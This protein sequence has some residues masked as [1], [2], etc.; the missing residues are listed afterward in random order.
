MTQAP[1][2]NIPGEVESLREFGRQNATK[3]AI[4]VAVMALI[5]A[6][7]AFYRAHRQSERREASNLLNSWRDLSQLEEIVDRYSSSPTAPLALLQLAKA[8]F[9]NGNY[10]FAEEKYNEFIASFGDHLFAP[11]AELGIAHCAEAQGQTQRAIYAFKSFA[12]QYP[13]HF[14]KTQALFGQGRCH[15]DLNQLQE[16]RVIYETI[17]ADDPEGIWISRAEDALD[18]INRNIAS[19]NLSAPDETAA[20]AGVPA[21]SLLP[22]I[23]L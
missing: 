11:V 16:A 21:S 17:V 20:T 22:N 1:E 18:R 10:P 14:L 12:T 13:D 5:I 15:E 7:P 9:D 19:G 2:K 3:I 23:E 4:A 8:H 6:V